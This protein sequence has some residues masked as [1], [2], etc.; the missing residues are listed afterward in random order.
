[1][2][3]YRIVHKKYADTLSGEGARL[4]GGR[5]NTKGN[6]MI[7]TAQSSSLAMLEMLV[8]RNIQLVGINYFLITIQ[9][10]DS[11]KIKNIDILEVPD[12]WDANPPNETTKSIG[13]T[14][15][16]EREYMILSV[17]SAVNPLES[18]FLINDQHPDF[19]EVSI[20]DKEQIVF[21]KRLL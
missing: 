2:N 13:D 18:N 1:M 20:I 6:S 11:I 17:P 16:N 19:R 8:Q 4:Y 7:Y 5:W 14:F 9:I 3:C 12:S 21:D 15:V 10:P